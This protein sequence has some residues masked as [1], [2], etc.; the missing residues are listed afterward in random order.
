MVDEGLVG[1]QQFRDGCDQYD[2][3]RVFGLITKAG[4]PTSDTKTS[5]R[6]TYG[7]IRRRS[8]PALQSFLSI[9]HFLPPVSILFNT[10]SD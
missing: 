9:L 1:V 3:N 6:V 10:L 5:S 2:A 4:F 8:G 7:F